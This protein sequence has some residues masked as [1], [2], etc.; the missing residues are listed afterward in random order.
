M[1]SYQ[2]HI[3]GKLREAGCGSSERALASRLNLLATLGEALRKRYENECSYEWANTPEYE[4]RTRALEERIST[5]A[6]DG[7]LHLFLQGDCRG[8]TVYVDAAP[9]P[10]NDYTRAH[11]LTI[12]TSTE[13]RRRFAAAK[14]AK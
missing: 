3:V 14:V 1:I 5:I 12:E 13:R 7:G 6:K 11:C 2:A 8:A 9:I 10:E 4:R